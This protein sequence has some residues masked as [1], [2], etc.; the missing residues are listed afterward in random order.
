MSSAEGLHG[1]ISRRTLMQVGLGAAAVVV[2]GSKIPKPAGDVSCKTPAQPAGPFYPNQFPADTDLDLTQ[3][4]GQDGGAEGDVLYVA[5]QI[6]DE[7]FKPVSGAL[8]EIWQANKYGRYHHEDDP[9]SAPLDPNFQ[10][11]G[12]VRTDKA[13][14]YSFKT[15]FPGAY[16]VNEDWTRT[17]HIHFKVAR[18]GYHELITQLY[19]AGQEL[20][21]TDLLVQ[22]VPEEERDRVIVELSDGGE[23]D[24]A[25]ARRCL[26]NIVLR[27]V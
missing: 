20:N 2:A 24:E 16:P 26:F 27:K 9:R 17:P 18:R 5:G 12:R 6:L 4:E 25:D 1:D 14:K 7:D 10:G 11:F 15:I 8:V 3:V 19:F 13:G 21:E 22:E 23:G